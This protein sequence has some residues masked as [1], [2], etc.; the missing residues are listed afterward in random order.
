M[1]LSVRSASIESDIH[2]PQPTSI[3]PLVLAV[4]DEPDGRDLVTALLHQVG[5]NVV[6]AASGEEALAM[7]ATR[8]PDLV[9]LDV[10]LPGIDGFETCRRLKRQLGASFPVLMLSGRGRSAVIEGLGAGADDYLP[11]PFDV[12]EFW[13]RVAALLRIRSAES[14]ARRRAERLLSLARLSMA[15]TSRLDEVEVMRLILGEAL[16]L[17]DAEGAAFY[18]WDGPEQVLR[19]RQVVGA[20]SPE[21]FSVRRLGERIT[22]QAFERRQ[23][24]W[25][26]DYGAWPSGRRDA[27][28]AGTRAAVAAPLLFGNEALGVLVAWQRDPSTRFD[29]EDAQLLGLLAGQAAASLNVARMYA[30]ERTAAT[31]AAE[32]AAQLV[33]IGESMADGILIVDGAG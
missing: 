13:A 9:V 10:V 16:R 15:V 3:E 29:G 22:G 8:P 33:A 21:A 24:I 7:A 25:V 14:A 30:A 12:E 26:N 17:L 20:A 31:R 1:A 27:Q 23:P 32:R 4:D 18:V 19:R 28:V 2:R 11:K 6:T 5:Y